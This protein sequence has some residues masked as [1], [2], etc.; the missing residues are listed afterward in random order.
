[1]KNYKNECLL[2]KE[3]LHA[4]LEW[5]KKDIEY[6]EKIELEY[7]RGKTAAQKRIYEWVEDILKGGY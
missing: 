1:M 2:I 4:L 7:H 3:E 5:L 6:N